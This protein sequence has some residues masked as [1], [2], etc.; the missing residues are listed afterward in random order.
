MIEFTFN[1]LTPGLDAAVAAVGTKIDAILQH[2]EVQAQ[3]DMRISAPWKDQTGNARQGLFAQAII[4]AG[5]GVRGRDSTGRFTSGADEHA[6]VLYHTVPYGLFLETKNS[7]VYRVIVPTMEV[8]GPQIMNDLR[9]IM[10]V[11]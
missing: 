6:L 11:L 7:G 9:V 10:A 1:T 5:S 4:T 3:N 8:I 2:Y